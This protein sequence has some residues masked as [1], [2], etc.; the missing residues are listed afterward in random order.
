MFRGAFS[1]PIPGTTVAG[2]TDGEPDVRVLGKCE[3]VGGKCM[4]KSLCS[5]TMVSGR[6]SGSNDILCCLPA[7]REVEQTPCGLMLG[8]CVNIDETPCTGGTNMKFSRK[9]MGMPNNVM[10]CAEK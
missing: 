4:H 3:R 7:G 6:C 1:I 10:C 8:K 2:V 9:C 5:N